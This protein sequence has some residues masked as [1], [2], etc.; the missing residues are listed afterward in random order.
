MFSVRDN[1]C[2]LVFSAYPH[3]HRHGTHTRPGQPKART[4][5]LLVNSTCPETFPDTEA[6]YH[7]LAFDTRWLCRNWLWGTTFGILDSQTVPGNCTE[8]RE[9]FMPKNILTA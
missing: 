1:N 2:K 9:K 7:V 6:K 5:W 3:G 8:R 4:F